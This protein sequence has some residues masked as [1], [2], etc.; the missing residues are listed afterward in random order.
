[1]LP[2]KNNN[3]PF[4]VLPDQPVL[5]TLIVKTSC[6]TWKG[7]IYFSSYDATSEILLLV[8][9]IHGEHQGQFLKKPFFILRSY[10][11][12]AV[13]KKVNDQIKLIIKS[14]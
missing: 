2:A 6:R 8:N 11:R 12:S 5:R 3:E 4:K 1:M 13:Y 9:A 10:N 7:C 14:S